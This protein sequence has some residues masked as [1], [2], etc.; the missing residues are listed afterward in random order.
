MLW[1]ASSDCFD[2]ALYLA[3]SCFLCTQT[4]SYQSLF[5]WVLTYWKTQWMIL[6]PRLCSINFLISQDLTENES[7][8]ICSTVSNSAAASS[9]RVSLYWKILSYLLHNCSFP[10]RSICWTNFTSCFNHTAISYTFSTSPISSGLQLPPFFKLYYECCPWFEGFCQI[11]K[12]SI[13][14]DCM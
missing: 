7:M 4:F 10:I 8:L 3:C 9:I 12:S 6:F 1:V 2:S 13:V 14:D 11:K 5:M